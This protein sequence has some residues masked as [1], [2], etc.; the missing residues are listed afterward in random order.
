MLDISILI[1]IS[2]FVVYVFK[3]E[4]SFLKFNDIN[5]KF[6]EEIIVNET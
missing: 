6:R 5:F 4:M 3:S 1:I 2:S